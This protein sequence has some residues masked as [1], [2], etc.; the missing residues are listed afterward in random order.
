MWN[1]VLNSLHKRDTFL[2]KA[3]VEYYLCLPYLKRGF[4][5]TALIS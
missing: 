1:I 2:R 4:E 3:T 5:T